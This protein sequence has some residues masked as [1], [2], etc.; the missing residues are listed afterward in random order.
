MGGG[1]LACR[2]QQIELVL[3]KISRIDNF[4]ETVQYASWCWWR[5]F[6][7]IVGVRGTIVRARGARCRWACGRTGMII[8]ASCPDKGLRGDV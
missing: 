4:G 3:D 7:V 2:C 6:V 1:S 8:G 5:D